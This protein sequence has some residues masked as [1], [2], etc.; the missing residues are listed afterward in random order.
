MRVAVAE[1]ALFHEVALL[2]QAVLVAVEMVTAH[3][4]ALALRVL[5]TLAVEVEVDLSL[6][7]MVAMAVLV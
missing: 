5:Q 7:E 4:V 1:V 2:A 3:L 6:V